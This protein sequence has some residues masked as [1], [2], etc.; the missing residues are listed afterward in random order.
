LSWSRF[1][2]AAVITPVA[3]TVAVLITVYSWIALVGDAPARS[4][5]FLSA[6]IGIIVVVGFFLYHQWSALLAV[7]AINSL[8][9]LIF[10]RTNHLYRWLLV[11]INLASVWIIATY[12][13]RSF[14]GAFD[15]NPSKSTFS[16]SMTEPFSILIALAGGLAAAWCWY[17]K[18]GVPNQK[19]DKNAF[20]NGVS[21]A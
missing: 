3:V 10:S 7:V 11:P 9:A 13:L 17:I 5:D 8:F 18:I 12:R 6:F 2:D 19:S 14:E 15:G 16:Q 20:S 21:S 1:V 4:F